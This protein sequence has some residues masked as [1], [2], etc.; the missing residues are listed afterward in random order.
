MER[1]HLKA[2][3]RAT[4]CAEER[5]D[6]VFL[7]DP[8]WSRVER[9]EVESQL[10]AAGAAPPEAEVG[11]LCVRTGGTGGG[12]KFA[13]HDEQTLAAAA[14]GFCGHFGL[15][16][17]NAVNVLPP[18]HMS[19]LMPR[20]RCAVTGGEC[21]AWDW[22]HL[23]AGDR[24]NLPRRTD[25]WTLSLVP[26]QLQRLLRSAETIAWLRELRIIFLGGGPVWPSLAE[27]AARAELPV[28]LTYG[29]T[30][31]AAMVAALAP[32]DFLNGLRSCGPSL[33]HA[34]VTLTMD[35]AVKIAGE[36]VFR[37]YFPLLRSERVFESGDS[38]HI[39]ERG[40]IHLFG[41][42][43]LAIVTGGKKVWPDEVEAVLRASGEFVD[44][45]VLGVPD[46]EWGEVI[47]ACYHAGGRQPDIGRATALLAPHQRPKRFVPLTELPRN[48]QGK[49]NRPALRVAVQ[50]RG[51][52]ISPARE[53]PLGDRRQAGTEPNQA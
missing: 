25:G 21:L 52:S 47:V 41:R 50:A 23:E 26:T 30:E 34:R 45:A 12:V 5:G 53:R 31:T 6:W 33:P 3:L 48:L 51:E 20:V 19:G 32:A 24:P 42:R 46:D 1:A 36:S 4:G 16:R 49:I 27:D 43:D 29:M 37:G 39:D 22:A 35:G 9:T 15:D 8:G 38:G 7:R 14:A 10:F 17:V 18:W 11:W 44:V 13:R 40:H 28:S 2:L